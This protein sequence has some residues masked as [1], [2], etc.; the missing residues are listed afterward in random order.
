MAEYMRSYMRRWRRTNVQVAA[1]IE[2]SDDL[3]NEIPN[4]VGD[5]KNSVPND[6]DEEILLRDSDD[7][8]HTDED[9][10]LIED[11]EDFNTTSSDSIE[12]SSD[13]DDINACNAEENFSFESELG[14][15]QSLH[16]VTREALNHLLDILRNQG[17]RLP[18]DFRT[19]VKTPRQINTC[20]Y[21]RRR[22]RKRRLYV[23]IYV[24]VEG[25]LLKAVS[26]VVCLN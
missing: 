7:T 10:E 24:R 13:E 5:G 26:S 22:R 14:K 6:V 1:L 17:H 3:D 12:L 20:K 25:F 2:S 9:S 8:L 23:G 18:K 21:C 4:Q 15:W 19:L 11:D 16:K